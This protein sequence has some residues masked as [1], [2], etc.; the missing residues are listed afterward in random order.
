VDLHFKGGLRRSVFS[1][2]SPTASRLL[3]V[4]YTVMPTEY[5]TRDT[6]AKVASMDTTVIRT[7]IYANS[8]GD[9]PDRHCVG[10]ANK[11]PTAEPG[12]QPST[13]DTHFR[14][15][16]KGSRRDEEQHRP[17]GRV[18][19]DRNHRKQSGEIRGLTEVRLMQRRP[20][21]VNR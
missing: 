11:V 1:R 2:S 9:H 20:A 4:R 15:F 14:H 17:R 7:A 10:S 3:E 19:D 12:P 8:G 16:A 6:T 13:L 5:R 18:S 21:A